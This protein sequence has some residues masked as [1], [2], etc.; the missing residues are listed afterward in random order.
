MT[1]RI[2]I[3]LTAQEDIPSEMNKLRLHS[4]YLFAKVS[5]TRSICCV[6]R[7]NP[8]S[9]SSFRKATSKGSPSNSKR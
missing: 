1:I 6:S 7:G 5:I 4:R 3:M 9:M 2:A 8:T